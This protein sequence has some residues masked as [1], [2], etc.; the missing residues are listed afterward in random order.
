MPPLATSTARAWC[1]TNDTS[2]HLDHIASLPYLTE[3]TNFKGRVFMTHASKA[4]GL[5]LIKDYIRVR[6][7]TRSRPRGCPAGAGPPG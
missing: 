5:L 4:I 2:F 6:Y 7:A 3:K 1:G